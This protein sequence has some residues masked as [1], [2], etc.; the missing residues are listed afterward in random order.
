MHSVARN[1]SFP[2]AERMLSGET[3]LQIQK[4]EGKWPPRCSYIYWNLHQLLFQ[5]DA[6]TPSTDG[7]QVLVFVFV[8]RPVSRSNQSWTYEI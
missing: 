7:A 2:A 8:D 4:S 6:L 3:T 5:L 1:A